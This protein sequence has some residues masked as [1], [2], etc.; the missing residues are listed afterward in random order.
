MGVVALRVNY[1]YQSATMSGFAP[2]ADPLAP[3]GPGSPSNTPVI[4]IAANDS[5]GAPAPPGVGGN[6]PTESPVYSG[7]YGLGSQA[8]WA[9]NVR[10]YRKLMCL[11]AIYRR[12]V[13][14]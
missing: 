11:Q 3:P 14:Q 13:F 6:V 2:A 4:P 12:E 1:A 7:Q 9:Q 5:V 8:A 10:P